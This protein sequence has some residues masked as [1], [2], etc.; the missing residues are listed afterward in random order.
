MH[1]VI[2]SWILFGFGIFVNVVMADLLR[3]PAQHLH[4]ETKILT[5]DDHMKIRD[6][7]FIAAA[8]THPQHPCNYL[9]NCPP[10]HRNLKL[11]PGHTYS[12][13]L[14]KL[15]PTPPNK[16]LSKHI[17]DTIATDSIRN[18]PPNNILNS[19][20]PLINDNEDSLP[21]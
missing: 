6:T 13:T 8:E 4:H 9:L 5:L 10:T 14:H 11:T 3:S 7:H 2:Y 20:P 18:L 21:R 16:L 17:H 15:P 1:K 19:S 12:K